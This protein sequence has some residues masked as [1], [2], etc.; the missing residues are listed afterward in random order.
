M[1]GEQ[2]TN[3]FLSGNVIRLAT[4]PQVSRKGGYRFRG[5]EM[6]S[7]RD[8]CRIFLIFPES[9]PRELF[10]F[11]SLCIENSHI[12]LR[13]ALPNNV[14]ED[15]TTILSVS[16]HTDLILEPLR[17]VGV[18]DAV[19]AAVC[20]A[21]MDLRLRLALDEPYWVSKG[22]FIHE[23]FSHILLNDDSHEAEL[24]DRAFNHALRHILSIIPGTGVSVDQTALRIEAQEHFD[25]LKNWLPKIKR[26]FTGYQSECDAVSHELGLKGRA[27]AVL[28][29]DDGK[30]AII[31]MKSGRVPVEDHMLQLFA[32][33]ML[34]DS[35]DRIFNGTLFYSGSGESKEVVKENPDF[36]RRILFG[37]NVVIALKRSH[38]QNAHLKLNRPDCSGKMC[39]SRNPCKKFVDS[40]QFCISSD[41]EI[42]SYYERWFG[43]L[44]VDSWESEKAILI[45]R[46]APDIA[47][48]D[49]RLARIDTL[50]VNDDAS[51]TATKSYIHVKITTQTTEFEIATGD[52]ICLSEDLNGS[53][54]T[55]R[56]YATGIDPGFIDLKIKVPTSHVE[57]APK[58]PDP[59]K[60]AVYLEK[61]SFTRGRE[62]AAKALARFIM[63][64]P[65]EVLNTIIKGVENKLISP[66]SVMDQEP[67]GNYITD[68][69]YAEGLQ[70]ELNEDQ[71]AAV[72]AALKSQD[73]HIIHG[74]PGTGK[75]RVLARLIRLCLDRGERVLVAAPT[76]T[77]LDRILGA[78]I[79]LG[80][81]DFLRIGSRKNISTEFLADIQ[82]IGLHRVLSD[83]FI[84]SSNDL[85]EFKRSFQNIKLIGATAFQCASNPILFR[86]D[87]DTVVI[88][89]AGQLD[90]PSAL[91][92]LVYG[93]KFVLCG[94]H[95][96]LPPIVQSSRYSENSILEKS[97]FERLYES[98]SQRKISKLRIQYRM[99][100]EIQD[101]PS[102]LFYN[103]EL[104]P[105]PETA[106]RRLSIPLNGD[107]KSALDILLDPNEPVIF[108]DIV[109]GES[110]KSRALEAEVAC[111]LA[112][113]YLSHGIPA[114]EIGIITPYKAQQ[115]LIRQNLPA[116]FLV[117]GMS[118]SVDTVDAFQGGEREVIILSLVRSDNVTSFLA[119]KKRLNVSLSR[120]R[121]KLI[122]LG[123]EETLRAHELFEAVLKN[124]KS[125]KVGSV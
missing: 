18:T 9:L 16:P 123:H 51:H 79:R 73:F 93:R 90:E 66:N 12:A 25:R 7:T 36:R 45:D 92:P 114:R 121:S 39:F 104:L 53:F 112:R 75:T 37:R 67:D 17:I 23:L 32:Y 91:G 46:E 62:V 44:S 26:R 95:Y 38:A 68:F 19:Q 97:L 21:S 31:E 77:A 116:E 81:S 59:L 117:P 57:N 4:E 13:N 78:C 63:Y 42:S 87:F 125:V 6:C 86:S 99:N 50:Q 122:L 34:F 47:L 76:N 1:C 70:N 84:R 120:A 10:D 2:R 74:P 89:E 124:I 96:Q 27:D 15:G 48:Q 118:I 65:K 24:F 43:A 108:G 64:A 11:P 60:H 20:H 103:G 80:I 72:L 49:G 94:D 54:Q 107:K 61:V 33:T 102:K 106:T 22:K 109:F 3:G 69:C 55:L 56:G 110:G 101:I 35:P 29:G 119:D 28:Y 111:K 105:G 40:G 98:A 113:A 100:R 14:L 83:D 30:N 8:H 58:L 82:S 52:E 71:A 41:P 115:Q 85:Q 88:D 5:I